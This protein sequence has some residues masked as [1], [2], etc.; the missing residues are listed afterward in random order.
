MDRRRWRSSLALGTA[1]GFVFGIANLL[2]TWSRPL[3]DDSPGVLLLFYGPMF[4]VWAFVAFRATRRT[5]RLSFGVVNGTAV[6]FA[7]FCVFI[8]LNFVRV[9]LFLD[10]LT[11]RADWHN[12]M[13]RFHAE[14]FESLRLFV[15][16]SYLRETPLKIFAASMLGAVIAVLGGFA[17]LV[18]RPRSL[19]PE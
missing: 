12:M 3:E 18:S 10:E 5:G 1:V 7:T 9:N 6:A 16:V 14:R 17:G 19:R 11:G 15:N 4:L 2:L 13:Y 8:L